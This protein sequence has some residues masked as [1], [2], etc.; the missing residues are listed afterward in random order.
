MKRWSLLACLTAWE[1]TTNSIV[2]VKR[3]H[4]KRLAIP[5]IHS[6]GWPA[7]L[8]CECLYKRVTTGFGPW[9]L[10]DQPVCYITRA[11]LSYHGDMSISKVEVGWNYDVPFSFF[12]LFI[13]KLTG[14]R[15]ILVEYK[16]FP[17]PSFQDQLGENLVH[18]LLAN[19]D[20]APSNIRATMS[21]GGLSSI[22]N[23][24]ACASTSQRQPPL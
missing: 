13:F 23:L 7:S 20:P 11:I 19:Q 3:Y 6:M 22:V 1:E 2:P 17:P 8:T 24:I 18:Y 12:A 9:K 5:P 14:K 21:I 15:E 16:T 10:V 4:M